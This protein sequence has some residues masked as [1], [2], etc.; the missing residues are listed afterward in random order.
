MLLCEEAKTLFVK[1]MALQPR[2]YPPPGSLTRNERSEPESERGLVP[3][4]SHGRDLATHAQQ[5]QSPHSPLHLNQPQSQLQHNQ[6]NGMMG[7]GGGI[8]YRKSTSRTYNI[9][10][11]NT[12]NNAQIPQDQQDPFYR[13]RGLTEER[14][15]ETNGIYGEEKMTL[16][17]ANGD[18][19]VQVERTHKLRST[20]GIIDDHGGAAA[21]PQWTMRG[22]TEDQL[23]E[24]DAEWER[25]AKHRFAARPSNFPQ[26]PTS[27]HSPLMWSGASRTEPTR[28]GGQ[29]ATQY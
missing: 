3:Y 10:D 19:F 22:V 28:R 1:L 7:T 23:D 29:I 27:Q 12:T 14:T 2:H 16:R 5:H 21:P 26:I 11:M 18:R 8:V 24:F 20:S 13:S 15:L 17:R 4:A 9:N 6:N 25:Q